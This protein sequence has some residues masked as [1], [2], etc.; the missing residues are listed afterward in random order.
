LTKNNAL[1]LLTVYEL[2]AHNRGFDLHVANGFWFEVK[3][4]VAQDNDVGQFAGRDGSF[5][6][7]LKFR[8]RRAR[9]VGFDR[10]W[11]RDLFLRD[12]VLAPF[13]RFC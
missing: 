12:L 9:G 7:F 13:V 8:E 4:V 2:A 11:Q 10:L 3:D 6:L 1:P 5:V